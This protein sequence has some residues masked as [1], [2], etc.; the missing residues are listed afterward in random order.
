MMEIESKRVETK[1]TDESV[2]VPHSNY[3]TR[4]DPWRR[5]RYQNAT[6]IPGKS[7]LKSLNFVKA[8]D[9]I[10]TFCDPHVFQEK[11][12]GGQTVT[13]D[14]IVRFRGC[15]HCGKREHK[16][17]RCFKRKRRIQLL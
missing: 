11:S 16:W 7:N 12:K 2:N 14:V 13:E 1:S 3:Q 15:F 4:H 17:Q 8:K 9:R 10:T 6:C 5:S